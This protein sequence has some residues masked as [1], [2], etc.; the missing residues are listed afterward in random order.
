MNAAAREVP[1]ARLQLYY[2]Y[3]LAQRDDATLR[4]ARLQQTA[5]PSATQE[6]ELAR[7]VVELPKLEKL[8]TQFHAAQTQPIIS[9]ARYGRQ[10][11]PWDGYRYEEIVDQGYAFHQPFATT[12]EKDNPLLDVG[13]SEKRSKNVVWYP[14]YPF[15]A[16]G[17][18]YYF[19]LTSTNALT[20]VSWSCALAAGRSSQVSLS[21]QYF[22]QSHDHALAA[23]IAHHRPVRS[24][25]AVDC[26]PAFSGLVRCFFMRTL[27]RASLFCCWHRFSIACRRDGGGVRRWLR[28]S[29]PLRDRRGCSLGLFWR[30]CICSK[31]RWRVAGGIAAEQSAGRR[32]F[33][34]GVISGLWAC[35]VTC[36]FCAGNMMIRWRSCTPRNTGMWG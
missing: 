26:G 15:L 1:A 32:R 13:G 34:M 4:I 2:Y 31:E 3:W 23:R 22:F 11:T 35:C 6:S 20:V 12:M 5:D 19:S 28:H 21:R 27:P 18:A 33:V 30:R 8:V 29:P 16:S 10:F 36:F 24:G 9:Y 7:L 17:I 14:L 25:R